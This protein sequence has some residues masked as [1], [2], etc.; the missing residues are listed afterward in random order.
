MEEYLQINLNNLL[1]KLGE[2]ETKFIL[3]NFSCAV[4]KDIED[5]LLNKAIE[6]NNIG[7]AKTHLVFLKDEKPN[8][9]GY[10]AVTNKPLEVEI[11]ALSNTMKRRIQKTLLMSS[12]N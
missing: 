10:F 9:V 6:F 3:S 5:F 8:L 1:K 7:F 4:N 12:I 2:D 11:S